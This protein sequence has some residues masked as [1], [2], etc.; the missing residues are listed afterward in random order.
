V[1]ANANFPRGEVGGTGDKK[2]FKCGSCGQES[3]IKN[4]LPLPK[5]THAYGVCNASTER[6]AATK[7]ARRA[8]RRWKLGRSSTEEWANQGWASALRLQAV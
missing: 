8:E 4:N 2:Y 3:V 6:R 7:D 5:S 1:S